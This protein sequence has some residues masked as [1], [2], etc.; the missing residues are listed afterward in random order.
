MSVRLAILAL[1][2]EGPRHGY[3]LKTEFDAR[4]G[5]AWPL[6]VGQVYTTLDRLERDGLVVPVE[7][8]SSARNQQ[9]FAITD[10]G[11]KTLDGWLMSGTPGEVPR[12][13]LL[14][15]VLVVAA[16]NPVAALEVISAQ[17][18]GLFARLQAHRRA[19][20]AGDLAAELVHDALAVRA[21]ADL[22]WLDRCE[23]RL[24]E[25]SLNGAGRHPER[26]RS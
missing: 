4:T 6:N 7:G 20:P 22:R 13:D 25:A 14:V 24:R 18:A 5:G 15:K 3:Q 17:R 9:A 10:T 11:R 19:T 16:R 12:D 2:E 26:L 8:R 1:L 23:A 21:E